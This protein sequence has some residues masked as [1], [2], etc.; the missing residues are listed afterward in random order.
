M[1]I[2]RAISVIVS[3]LFLAADSA[4]SQSLIEPIRFPTA[5]I[6]SN[7][8]Y[9]I[10]Q[11]IYNSTRDTST[12]VRYRLTLY[13]TNKKEIK[14][15]SYTFNPDLYYN[16][17]YSFRIPDIL[18]DDSYRYSIE[19]I[20]GGN[21]VE[22]RYYYYLKYPIVQEFSIN[23]EKKNDVDSLPPEYLIQYLHIDR[24]NTLRNGYNFLFFSSSG[25]ASFGIGMLFYHVIHLGT[26]STIIYT[27]SFI[28]SGVGISAAGYYGY[29]YMKN[30][31][32]LQRILEIN[33][34]VSI[35]GG[36]RDKKVNAEVE[37]S[38]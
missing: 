8:P 10:W 2:E 22:S 19:R 13:T 27:V 25:L 24:N 7:Q 5:T 30:R 1:R 21:P 36:I 34:R 18:K 31:G 38:F 6:S 15:N 35:N 37:F 11:D 14:L 20:I 33:K 16:F 26:I 17:F 32:K 12:D 23:S 29:H 9:F 3:I 28:S 4:F